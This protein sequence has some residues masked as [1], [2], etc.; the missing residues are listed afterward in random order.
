MVDE[1][2]NENTKRNINKKYFR[3]GDVLVYLIFIL[4]FFFMG[5]IFFALENEKPSKVEI[6]VNSKLEYVYPLQEEEQNIFV[7]TEIGG[8]D[9]QFK[10][11]KVRVTTSNSPQKLC[12]RQGWIESPGQ[13]IIGVPDKLLIKIVGEDISGKEWNDDIDFIVR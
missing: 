4:I 1:N 5:N 12:V 9:I 3:T 6:Y 10:D 8:V 2:I 7:N 13:I 11:F